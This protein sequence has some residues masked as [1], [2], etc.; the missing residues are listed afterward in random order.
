MYPPTDGR[1]CCYR[2]RYRSASWSAESVS[3]FF[4][5]YTSSWILPKIFAGSGSCFQ[6]VRGLSLHLLRSSAQL[7][8]VIMI[9]ESE[10]ECKERTAK[11]A[12]FYRV[13]LT[14]ESLQADERAFLPRWRSLLARAGRRCPDRSVY[15]FGR[16]DTVHET[17]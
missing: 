9:R 5:T 16:R 3:F 7:Q 14:L 4:L 10:T 15:L 17:R 8:I 2:Y 6:P 12:R 1:L 13:F 11:K